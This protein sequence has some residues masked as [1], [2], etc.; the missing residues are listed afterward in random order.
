MRTVVFAFTRCRPVV[1]FNVVSAA[2]MNNE[3][4]AKLIISLVESKPEIWDKCLNTYKRRNA[5][6]N[7]WNSIC[8]TLNEDF[9]TFSYR[10]KKSFSRLIMKKWTNIRDHWRKWKKKE[11][12]TGK[13]GTRKPRKY[14]YHDQLKFLEN[15]T[16]D[17]PIHVKNIKKE[18][19][20]TK[21]LQPI[22]KVDIGDSKADPIC[23]KRVQPKRLTKTKRKVLQ[24][25]SNDTLERNGTKLTREEEEN[26]HILFFKGILPTLNLLDSKQVVD[27]QIEILQLLKKIRTNSSPL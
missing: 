11:K 22:A 5:T 25:K 21:V 19:V 12:N 27:F 23:E 16:L 26:P 9:P 7:A 1:V 8:S 14:M 20:D 3:K 17:L 6:K 4:T 13:T 10:E 24:E 15:N 2:I 18:V